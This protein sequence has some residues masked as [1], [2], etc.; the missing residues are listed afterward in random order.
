[1]RSLAT[2][3]ARSSPSKDKGIV[4]VCQEAMKEITRR[5]PLWNKELQSLVCAAFVIFRM[6]LTDII[7]V[8]IVTFLWL[9]AVE[10]WLRAHDG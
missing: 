3:T 8:E 10:K 6:R 1:M 4:A 7:T 5:K 9:T 2:S